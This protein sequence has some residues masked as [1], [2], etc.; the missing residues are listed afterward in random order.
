LGDGPFRKALATHRT[1]QAHRATL[2]AQVQGT[3]EY[4]LEAV[5]DNGRKDLWPATAPSVNQTAIA[6]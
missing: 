6:W 1:R 4:Y 5:L 3:E 2:P